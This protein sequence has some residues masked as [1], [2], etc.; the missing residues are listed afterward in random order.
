MVLLIKPLSF[1]F[2]NTVAIVS[3]SKSPKYGTFQIKRLSKQ[4]EKLAVNMHIRLLR[5]RLKSNVVQFP[6]K[7][8][9]MKGT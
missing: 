2:L 1:L 7:G 6:I 8:G 3:N 9:Q 4:S 5:A